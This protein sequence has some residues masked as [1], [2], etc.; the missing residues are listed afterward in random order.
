MS[1]CGGLSGSGEFHPHA[2]G[3]DLHLSGLNM[4]SDRLPDVLGKVLSFLLRLCKLA[5]DAL[6]TERNSA[7]V[8]DQ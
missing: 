1:V 8:V 2:L 7:A 4:E 3:H 6:N 5:T